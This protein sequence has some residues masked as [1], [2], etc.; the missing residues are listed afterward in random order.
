MEWAS[1]ATFVSV[2][3]AATA[4]LLHTIQQSRCTNIRCCGGVFECVRNVPDTMAED[5]TDPTPAPASGGGTLDLPI[6]RNL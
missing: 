3:C 4:G 6:R 5:D 1:L 2:C